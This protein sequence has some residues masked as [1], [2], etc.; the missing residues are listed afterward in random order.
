MIAINQDTLGKQAFCFRDNGDYEI[1]VK[2]LAGEE[3]V[4]CLL[5]RSDE[6]K[7]V[8]VNISILLKSNDNYWATDPYEMKNYYITTCATI[9]FLIFTESFCSFWYY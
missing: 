1:W 7:T 2:K 9:E 3:K 6:V 4:V 8:E 5:N